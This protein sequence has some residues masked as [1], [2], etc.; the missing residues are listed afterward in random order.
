MVPGIVA[1]MV[2]LLTMLLTALISAK[3]ELHGK[4]IFA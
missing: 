3:I 1:E 4:K 2:T